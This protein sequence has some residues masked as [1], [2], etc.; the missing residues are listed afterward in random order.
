MIKS[1][2]KILD[3]IFKPTN[4]SGYSPLPEPPITPKPTA[5]TGLTYKVKRV[6]AYVNLRVNVYIDLQDTVKKEQIAQM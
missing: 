2:R 1:I 4:W 6:N 3:V 5:G